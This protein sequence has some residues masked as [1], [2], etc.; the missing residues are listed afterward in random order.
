MSVKCPALRHDGICGFDDFVIRKLRRSIEANQQPNAIEVGRDLR[1]F[2]ARCYGIFKWQEIY[3]DVSFGCQ[4]RGSRPHC[5]GPVPL[6]GVV[7][8][9]FGPGRTN[10]MLSTPERCTRPHKIISCAR[11]FNH[12]TGTRFYYAGTCYHLPKN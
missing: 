2:E 7:E 10:R 6:S 1:T 5:S 9:S 8:R 11:G 4:V 12:R 3:A